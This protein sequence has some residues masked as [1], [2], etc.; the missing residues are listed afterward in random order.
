MMHQKA[1]NGK[2]NVRV[3]IIQ[4]AADGAGAL[5]SSFVLVNTT[6]VRGFESKL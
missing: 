4:F 2:Q 1:N 6:E 3:N 5:S